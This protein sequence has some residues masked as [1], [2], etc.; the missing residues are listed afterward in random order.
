MLCLGIWQVAFAEEKA[1]DVQVLDTFVVTATRTEK[2]IDNAPASV[3]VITKEDMKK[4]SIKTI[5]DAIKHEAGVYVKRD[6]GMSDLLTSVSMRGLT[7]QSRTLVLLN[8]VPV[9][10][11]YSG[12]VYWSALGIDNVERIEI[13]RGGGSALYGGNAMGGV[14]NIITTKPEKL[15]AGV[16]GGYGSDQTYKY[17]AFVGKRY[18]RFRIRVGYEAE[19]TDGYPTKLATS[20]ISSGAGTL[21][22]GYGTIDKDGNPTWVCGD[23]GDQNSERSNVNLMASYDVT[24][25]GSLS[26]NFQRGTTD[27]DYERPNTYLTDASGNPSFSGLVDA[28][29]GKYAFVLPIFYLDTAGGTE[30]YASSLTYKESFGP[31]GFTGRIG[32]QTYDTWGGS[33]SVLGFLSATYDDADGNGMYYSNDTWTADLQTDIPL[34]DKHL[35]TTG[36]YFRTDSF[37]QDCYNLSHYRDEDSKLDKVGDTEGKARFYALYL[38]DEWNI[39]DQLTVYGGVRF[40]FWESW[41][42][43]SR[44]DVDEIDE[45]FDDA[46]DNAISPQ[47]AGVWNPLED[48]YVRASVSK[49]FRPPTIYDLFKTWKLFSTTYNCNP[50]LKP[51]SIWTYEAGVDQYV[52]SR[53]LKLSATCFYTQAKDLIGS[54]TESGQN[55]KENIAEADIRGC[56]LQA[57]ARPLEWLNIWANYT[58]TDS[59]VKKNDRAP[60]TVG[61]HLTE[62]PAQKINT[63]CDLTYKWFKASL[64]GDYLGRIYKNELNDD[65]DDV[66]GAYSKRWLWNAKLIYSPVE[67]LDCSLSVDNIFDEEYFSGYGVGRERSYFFEIKLKY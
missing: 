13:T 11:G 63:G 64:V 15:E 66:Y 45:E 42:G 35:L 32:Y 5:D 20:M 43:K 18:D 50:N 1:K 12:S 47:I 58:Y 48:T 31:V 39:T 29:A 21:T 19:T 17:G 34:G 40:D 25:T 37:D 54:Y 27:W 8:G 61:K 14:I 65:K 55:Y 4:F 62:Y 9:N 53:K 22:G 57:S 52:F 23:K 49:A 41:D 38:Q 6:A 2:K 67:Y 46:D 10:E 16:H 60:S 56:E 36:A 7:G 44:H 24:D 59:E 30:N 26:F 28:G 33:P 3:T 51:E